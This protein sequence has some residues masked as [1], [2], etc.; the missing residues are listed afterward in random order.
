[1]EEQ[2]WELVA[3]S[4]E[5]QGAERQSLRDRHVECFLFSNHQHILRHHFMEMSPDPTSWGGRKTAMSL[6]SEKKPLACNHSVVSTQ[7]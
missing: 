2:R 1:M 6:H 3:G 5:D 4:C 7:L